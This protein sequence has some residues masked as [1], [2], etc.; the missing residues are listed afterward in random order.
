MHPWRNQ[1]PNASCPAFFLPNWASFFFDLCGMLLYF[2]LHSLLVNTAIYTQIHV[3]FEP[4]FSL[5]K[6]MAYIEV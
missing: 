5:M 6:V 2:P 1:L 3:F 4:L